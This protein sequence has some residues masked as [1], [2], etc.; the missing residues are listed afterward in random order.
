MVLV[1]LAAAAAA[2]AQCLG[3]ASSPD[4]QCSGTQTPSPSVIYVSVSE[5]PR[6]GASPLWHVEQ[7]AAVGTGWWFL[8]VSHQ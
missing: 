8:R 7:A 2:D 6:A 1:T 5:M 3:R 4:A